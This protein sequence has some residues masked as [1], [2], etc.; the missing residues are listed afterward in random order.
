MRPVLE[1][2]SLK[3]GYGILCWLI[4]QDI[5][6]LKGQTADLLS[7]MAGETTVFTVGSSAGRGQS[8]GRS[9]GPRGRPLFSPN[10][11]Y[12]RRPAPGRTLYSGCVGVG[13]PTSRRIP[14]DGVDL[15]PKTG[16]H[17]RHVSA[18]RARNRDSCARCGRYPRYENSSAYGSSLSSKRTRASLLASTPRPRIGTCIDSSFR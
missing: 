1:G 3:G 15:S 12:T 7:K 16:L 8:S 4:V 10:P 6:Q 18:L 14:P 17:P 9:R 11:M 2:I 13:S 5:A